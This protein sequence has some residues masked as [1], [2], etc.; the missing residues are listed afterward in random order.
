MMKYIIKNCPAFDNDNFAE[1][2]DNNLCHMQCADNENC[3]MKHFIEKCKENYISDDNVFD[4]SRKIFA[5]QILDLLEIE[6]VNEW[7]NKRRRN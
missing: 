7:V 5:Q 1:C 3:V 4:I 6:E 2:K